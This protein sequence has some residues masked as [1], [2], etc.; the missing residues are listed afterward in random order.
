ML[1]VCE[2]MFREQKRR[3]PIIK[4]GN[5]IKNPVGK[6]LDYAKWKNKA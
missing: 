5:N 2:V 3:N 1:D 4:V 6:T